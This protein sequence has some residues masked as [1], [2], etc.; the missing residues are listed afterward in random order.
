MAW[1]RGFFKY[2]AGG[3]TMGAGSY[4]LAQEV[5]KFSTLKSN[6]ESMAEPEE[7]DAPQRKVVE[8][9]HKEW[10]VIG[11]QSPYYVRDPDKNPKHHLLN[12]ISLSPL[13]FKGLGTSLDNESHYE[14]L[15]GSDFI[16]EPFTSDGTAP[17]VLIKPAQMVNKEPHEIGDEEELEVS[18]A[19]KQAFSDLTKQKSPFYHS[20]L[21]FRVISEERPA[22]PDSVVITGK[23]AKALLDDINSTIC[24]PQH[25]TLY[26]SNCYSATIYGTG[27]LIELIDKRTGL[28]LEE[29]Q[30]KP[31][32]T[33]KDNKDIQAVANVLAKVSLDN[34]GRGV[35]N[36]PVV[37]D[38]L[39]IEIPQ[40]LKD[41]GILKALEA[42]KEESSPP[43][44]SNNL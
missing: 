22:N 24:E 12:R 4:Y 31:K 21:A 9:E 41:R 25:C 43:S 14:L 15:P 38:K 28:K 30:E 3:T 17:R 34:L 44:S 5:S 40:I 39:N 33:G 18:F 10:L 35:S 36:N 1:R 7:E 8:A 37:S 32:A 27:K 13:I 20:S 26:G 29:D 6:L 42:K 11:R 19:R 16:T 23:E 2:A